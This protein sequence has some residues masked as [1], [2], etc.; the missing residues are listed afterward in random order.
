[1]RASPVRQYVAG[2]FSLDGKPDMG[3]GFLKDLLIA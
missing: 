1:M 3:F 2:M